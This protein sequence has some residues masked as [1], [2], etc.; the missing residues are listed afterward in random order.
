MKKNLEKWG[1]VS[2][3]AQSKRNHN[4]HMRKLSLLSIVCLACF[5]S[6][7]KEETK[8]LEVTPTNITVYSEG[9]TQLTTNVDDATFKSADDFYATV[10]EVGLVTGNKVGET[11]IVV[12]S[13]HGTVKVPVTIMNKYSLYPDV[14]GLIGKSASDVTNVL[15]TSYTTS[16]TSSGGTNYTYINPTSY[17]AGIVATIESGKCSAIGVLI[18]T[19]NTSMLTKHLLERYSVAGM[20]NDY[21]FFLNHDKNVVIALNVYSASYLMVIY[22]PYSSSKSSEA[23]LEIPEG[24]R[25]F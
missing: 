20:Q 14:D 5:L 4:I 10:D 17:A 13:A 16:T 3:F 8:K 11:E 15:G 1:G 2:K 23:I 9:T 24:L 19:S 6:C 21:Y 22:M 25:V 18:S 7:S 12:S